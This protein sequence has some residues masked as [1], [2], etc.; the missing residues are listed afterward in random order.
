MFSLVM[1]EIE[2]E[3]GGIM[4]IVI[5]FCWVWGMLSSPIIT[6]IDILKE[7]SRK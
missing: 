1:R 5:L 7:E 3:D 6:R 2:K 4:N